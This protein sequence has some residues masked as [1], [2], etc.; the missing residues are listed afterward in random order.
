MHVLRIQA[1]LNTALFSHTLP[2]PLPQSD[3]MF[4]S[5]LTAIASFQALAEPN[6]AEFYSHLRQP[7]LAGPA[8][9]IIAG[10]T[11]FALPVSAHRRDIRQPHR[12]RQCR[13]LALDEHGRER[14][15]R[16]LR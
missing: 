15:V 8:T 2:Q 3:K 7:S 5:L 4:R 13:R 11:V 12:L 10:E 14:A 9:L 1:L 6:G 16:S